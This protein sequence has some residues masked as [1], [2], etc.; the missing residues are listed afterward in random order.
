MFNYRVP[1][2]WRQPLQ[3]RVKQT[4]LA[5]TMATASL[6]LSAC[7]EAQ[8]QDFDIIEATIDEMHQAIQSGQTTC[9]DIVES[10]IARAAAYNGSCTVLVTEDGRPLAQA[11]GN[12]RAGSPVVFPTQT[13]AADEILPDLELYEGLPLEY[14]RMEPTASDPTVSQQFGMRVGIPRA[15]QLNALEM[16]NIRGER[17]VA[18]KNEC[19]AHPSTGA[20][21]A[22]CPVECEAFRQQPD[23]RELAAQ[24]DAQYGRNPP[25]DELPMYCVNFSYKNWYDA[26]E[27]RATGGNDTNF[28]MDAPKVDSPDLRVLKEKGAIMFGV[29][30]AART[31]LG[32][33]GPEQAQT[34][35]PDGNYG[36]AQWGGQPCNAYDT[37][38]VTR[39][40]SS[41]SGVSV[42]ANL[43]QCSICEQGSASCKGPASRN[44]V[45]NFLTTRGL[46]MHGGM[47]SQRVGDRAGIHCRTVGD[48]VRVL[49]AIKGYKSD[50]MYT[51]IPPELIPDEPYVSF[52]VNEDGVA[53]KPLAGMRVALVREFMVKHSLNDVAISDQINGEIKR[54]VGEELGAELVQ[55][56]DPQYQTD[57]DIP[58]ITYTFQDAIREILAHNVPEF[59]WQR[60]SSGELEF[61]VDGWD[62]TS[63]D[64]AIALAM[65]TAPLSEKLTLRRLTSGMDNYKSPF[66]VNK[67]L[68]ERG[69]SRVFNWETFVAN[70]KWEDDEHRAGSVNAIGQQ[71]LRARPGQISYL[72]M[73]FAL[74]LIVHKVM[75]ENGIDAF[76]NPEVTLPHYKLG[77]PAEPTVDNRGTAS[78]CAQFTAVLGGPE[79]DVPAGYN[80][81][82]YEPRYEL[83]ADRTRY[84]SVPGTERSMLP[85]P[86]PV[87]L[88]VWGPPGGE[89][90]VIRVASAY[91]SATQHRIP[92]PDFGPIP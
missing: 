92:P 62:V 88:M 77:G 29:A 67:Y 21:P 83:S 22:S 41:G 10:Y 26:T 65:G 70:S 68:M 52:L 51:A 56:Y 8:S 7:S 64:Y 80:Q 3:Q 73:Q 66:T 43:V 28:A 15:G 12:V 13:V 20:L 47:N 2:T 27:M 84:I 81:I 11:L 46:M 19:D 87:S 49:D 61:A 79:I 38:R 9:A 82:V 55:T 57:P 32:F 58:V 78:C 16:L 42:A 34:Y 35:R 17:T 6:V 90:E 71:D 63:T 44:N 1:L 14:G 91:E 50:D 86:M 74:R 4:L 54:I 45:V 33:D 60:D 89:P 59:F 24:Y 48:V 39:G 18:C 76:V 5:A 30:T 75:Y 23:A 40:T 72:K 53:S 36:Y 31:G 37:E 25:L 69:D 85:V